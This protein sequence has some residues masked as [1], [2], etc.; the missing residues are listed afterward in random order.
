MVVSPHTDPHLHG[1]GAS[2]ADAEAQS[3]EAAAR[4]LRTEWQHT[5][6]AVKRAYYVE[7]QVL[8]LKVFDVGFRVALGVLGGFTAIALAVAGALLVVFGARRGLV[9]WTRDAWW[10]DL[11]VG[12]V[13]LA[14]LGLGAFLARRAVHRGTLART[15]AHLGLAATTDPDVPAHLVPPATRGAG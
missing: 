4:R 11:I 14:L 13:I 3:L 8:G 7:R 6:T 12:A 15:R 9:V 1:D 5:L 2:G 10:V